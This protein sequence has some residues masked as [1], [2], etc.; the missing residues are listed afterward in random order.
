[1]SAHHVEGDGTTPEGAYGIGQVM[2]GVD[3]DPGVHYAYHQLV[4]G[5]W[6]NEDPSSPAYNRFVH[7]PCGEVPHFG[8]DSE[9]LWQSPGAYAYFALIDYNTDP[10]VPGAGSAI[11]LHVSTG[12][13]TDGCVSLPEPELL[14]TLR[15]LY[16]G[17]SPRIAIGTTASI[18]ST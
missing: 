4:C 1:V 6:W 2:Y 15:W 18:R 8:G 13:P 7:V 3:P 17:R 12:G 5:D 9:A 14:R 10:A 11:F 16:P